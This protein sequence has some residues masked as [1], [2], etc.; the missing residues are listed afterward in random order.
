[1]AKVLLALVFVVRFINVADA[2]TFGNSYNGASSVEI[3][4]ARYDG[5]AWNYPG[6]GYQ[7]AWFTLYKTPHY[8]LSIPRCSPFYSY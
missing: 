7:F 5:A 4:Q 2:T 8:F 1:M 6:S 3:L